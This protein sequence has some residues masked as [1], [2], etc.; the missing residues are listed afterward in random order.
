[1][2]ITKI[3][4]IWIEG[5]PEAEWIKANPTARQA[6]PHNLWVRIYTDTGLIGLGETY[7]LPGAI[8][9]IIHDGFAS[10]LIGR[11][12]LDIENNWQNLFA[13]VNFCG[14]AGAE[15]R[16]ISAIDVALWDIVGQYLKQPIYNL[17][18]GRSRDRIEIYNTCVSSGRYQDY[19]DTTEGRAGQV[20]S[21]LLRNGVKA[22]KIWPFDQFGPS[23][24]GPRTTW[25]TGDDMGRQKLC[26]GSWAFNNK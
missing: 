23:L 10:L 5:V 9:S 17:L 7:Y 22:M 14:F 2:K 21:D 16:A 25:R 26:R 6:T 4:T 15:M 11:N 20:A 1:M 19:H 3:E 18:G 8:A 24:A 12:P 13:L